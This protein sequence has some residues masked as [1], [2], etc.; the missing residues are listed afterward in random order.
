MVPVCLGFILHRGA[1]VVVEVSGARRCDDGRRPEVLTSIQASSPVSSRDLLL[2]LTCCRL[3]GG[4]R[5]S[6]LLIAGLFLSSILTTGEVGRRAEG[7]VATGIRDGDSQA[8]VGCDDEQS[9]GAMRGQK[10]YGLRECTKD[11]RCPGWRRSDGHQTTVVVGRRS[12]DV[13]SMAV[14]AVNKN[15]EFSSSRWKRRRARQLH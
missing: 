11:W 6:A 3:L 14:V 1:S 12:S 4:A 15:G 9:G 7:E 10:W 8:G 2:P 5:S 13:R